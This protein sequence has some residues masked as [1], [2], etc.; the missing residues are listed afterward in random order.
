MADS[1]L[2]LCSVVTPERAVFERDVRFV[3][4]PAHD[5][6]IGILRHRASL[7]CKLD[8]GSLRIETEEGLEVF[9]ID[10]GFAE[11]VDN[12]LSILTEDAKPLAEL[13][14]ERAQKLLGE[15]REIKTTGPGSTALRERAIK[16]AKVQLRMLAKK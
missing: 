13:D 16:R 11:M 15:A 12:R 14:R 5:G 1:K 8:V 3:A 4:L 2:F 7:L 10:G 6:E 9:Y